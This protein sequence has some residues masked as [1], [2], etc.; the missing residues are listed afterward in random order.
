MKKAKK[1]YVS[2]GL[3][4]RTGTGNELYARFIYSQEVALNPGIAGAAANQQF[5]LSSIFDPDLTGVGH[6][7]VNHDQYAA[8][9]E[10]YQVLS[11]KYTFWMQPN[12]STSCIGGV[13]VS[14]VSATT[15]D[16]RVYIE[17]G[18]C[19][20]RYLASGA[21]IQPSKITGSVS[22]A[23]VHGVTPAQYKANDDYGAQFGANPVEE[24]Y[25][26]CF[27]AGTGGNDSGTVGGWIE[28]EYTCKLMGS[29]LNALS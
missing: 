2:R 7:P 25:L 1:N 20:W 29:R 24:A 12:N 21:G 6:Q 26:T 4:S 18:Q 13:F 15:T 10:R 5:R 17:N 22:L 16:P 28:L 27:A 8:I 19:N 9:Y 23:R 14:D 3:S 11:V